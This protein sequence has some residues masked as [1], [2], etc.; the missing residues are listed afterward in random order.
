MVINPRLLVTI[1]PD[2][3][4]VKKGPICAGLGQVSVCREPEMVFY[5]HSLLLVT[6]GRHEMIVLCEKPWTPLTVI[7]PCSIFYFTGKER[8]LISYEEALCS[9]VGSILSA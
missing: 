3:G 7:I 6:N 9:M 4:A 5:F 1:D 8:S 2:T